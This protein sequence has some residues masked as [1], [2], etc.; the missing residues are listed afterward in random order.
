MLERNILERFHQLDKAHGRRMNELMD[1]EAESVRQIDQSH[2]L[3]VQ[4]Y[5]DSLV[6]AR[7]VSMRQ[8]GS[9]V[10]RQICAVK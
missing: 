10:I 9:G 7:L 1:L 4:G 5:A 8:E 3:D 2:E 6:N